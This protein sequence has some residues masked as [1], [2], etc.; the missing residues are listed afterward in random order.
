[1]QQ[2]RSKKSPRACARGHEPAQASFRFRTWGGARAGAGRPP[3]STRVSHA[4]RG[5]VS[6]HVP[7]HV[8]LRVVVG[9]PNLRAKRAFRLIRQVL[10]VERAGD[11]RVTHYSVQSNHLHLI[12]ESASKRELSRGLQALGIRLARRLNALFERSGRVVADRYHARPLRTPLEVRRGLAYVLNNYRKH[13][14]RAGPRLPL[15]FLDG[16]SSAAWFDGWRSEWIHAPPDPRALRDPFP[17]L[18]SGVVPARSVLLTRGWRRHGLLAPFEQ[19][20]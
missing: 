9:V 6:P 11:A 5:S 14:D 13:A 1:M 7:M 3:S 8:T 18:P 15:S 20:R 12:V 16:C 17:R 4:A 10:G 2:G 19:S